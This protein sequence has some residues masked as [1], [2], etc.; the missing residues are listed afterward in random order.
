M[1]KLSGYHRERQLTFI[2]NPVTI[3]IAPIVVLDVYAKTNPVRFDEKSKYTMVYLGYTYTCIVPQYFGYLT[4]VS[5]QHYVY[6]LAYVSSC[7][8]TTEVHVL[9]LISV[10]FINYCN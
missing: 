1:Y 9:L 5:A 7:L 2:K 10:T 3:S 4:A 8:Y 6:M